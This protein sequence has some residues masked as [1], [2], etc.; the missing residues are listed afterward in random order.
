M[1]YGG[2]LLWWQAALAAGKVL[3]AHPRRV[4]GIAFSSVHC[5][6]VF[7]GSV[8]P[9]LALGK[10]QEIL[11]SKLIVSSS[12]APHANLHTSLDLPAQSC[13]KHLSS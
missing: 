13:G 6:V 8:L 9:P 5:R 4:I 3:W 11:T 12:L 2:A 1:G 10:R 7:A